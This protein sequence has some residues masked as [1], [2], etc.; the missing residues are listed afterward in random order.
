[1][2]YQDNEIP[3]FK[4]VFSS[5]L[6]DYI[7]L[8]RANG[9]KFNSTCC[10]ILLSFDKFIIDNNY[11]LV[12]NYNEIVSNWITKYKD[13][14]LSTRT[15][16]LN[17]VY[18]FM[19]YASKITGMQ[20]PD[21]II[22]KGDYKFVPYIFSNDEIKALLNYCYQQ[23]LTS[24]NDLKQTKINFYCLLCLYY[25]CGLRKKEALNL[26]RKDYNKLTKQITVLNGKNNVSRV[27]VLSDTINDNLLSLID[28]NNYINEDE[29]LFKESSMNKFRDHILY[30]LFKEA[31]QNAKI[32]TRFDGRTQR[33]HDLRHT[34][35]VNA[36]RKMKDEG[37]DE[38]TSLP[39]L[40]TYMG[41]NSISETE[42]YLRLTYQ[43]YKYVIEKI[44]QY[45]IVKEVSYEK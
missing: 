17:L 38:Y 1:M 39:Y 16:Y 8:K 40:S 36:L 27:I 13:K 24:S 18:Q 7:Q 37:M 43:D 3:P 25:G 33:I 44:E 22:L 34:F 26:K 31:L 9:Y 20:L 11:T 35:A 14:A 32:K 23:C 21:K 30:K 42:Y 45:N 6:V 29:Y 19:V 4:S 5:I 2:Y 41:H 28:F 10:Y 12:T 15:H